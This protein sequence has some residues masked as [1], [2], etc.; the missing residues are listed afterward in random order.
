MT[1]R[2]QIQVLFVDTTRSV[3][4]CLKGWEWKVGYW[5]LVVVKVW[6]NIPLGYQGAKQ[7]FCTNCRKYHGLSTKEVVQ[8]KLNAQGGET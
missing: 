3:N 4:C 6:I 1:L 5:V 2:S 8:I 7:R